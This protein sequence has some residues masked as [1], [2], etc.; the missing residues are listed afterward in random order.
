MKFSDIENKTVADLIKQKTELSTQLFDMKM[1]NTLGQLASPHQIRNVRRSIAKINT[2][3]V[4][5]A[6]R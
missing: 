6:A 1:K 4:R 2:A 3:I 5:K